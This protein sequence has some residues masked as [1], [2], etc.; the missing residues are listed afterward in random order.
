V[1]TQSSLTAA[2]EALRLGFTERDEVGLR[3]IIAEQSDN[4]DTSI[5]HLAGALGKPVWILNRY[6]QCWRWLSGRTDSPWYPTVRLFQQKSPGDR[7]GVIQEV[8]AALHAGK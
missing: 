2:L 8:A 6:D 5:A 3:G 1:T 7:A 4:V